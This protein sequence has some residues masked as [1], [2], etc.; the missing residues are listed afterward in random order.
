M[1]EPY[2]K[3]SVSRFVVSSRMSNLLHSWSAQYNG[4]QKIQLKMP[5]T[6]WRDQTPTKCCAFPRV[7]SNCAPDNDTEH[8]YMIARRHTKLAMGL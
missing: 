5:D 8:A 3:R 6:V 7:G 2:G 4:V 1:F